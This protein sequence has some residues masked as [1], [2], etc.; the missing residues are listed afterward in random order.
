MLSP[1]YKDFTIFTM[2][3]VTDSAF[4]SIKAFRSEVFEQVGDGMDLDIMKFELRYF[5]F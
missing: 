1:A 2:R 4:E 5:V 3:D